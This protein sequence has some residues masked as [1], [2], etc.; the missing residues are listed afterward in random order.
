MAV[1]LGLLGCSQE[2]PPT[3]ANP[4][5][6]DLAPTVETAINLAGEQP[7]RDPAALSTDALLQES[8]AAYRQRFIQADGRVIDWEGNA[9][10]VSEGQAYALLRA[11]MA[12]DPATF[13]LTLQWAE[14]NLR[15]EGS[16]QGDSLWA[17]KW[18]QGEDGS[19]GVIDGNFA[20]D[21]DIDAATALILAARRWNRPDYEALAQ[22]KLADL[23]DFSTLM[24]PAVEAQNS[25]R[26]L[27]PGP[28]Q[29]FQ[30]SPGKVYLNPSYLA[31]YAFRLFAQ[32]DPDRNWAALVES[33]YR[34]LNQTKDL[35]PQG[36]PGDW[37]VLEM[38]TQQLAPVG[39]NSTLKSHYGFDAYRVWW[40]I[41]LDAAW[42]GEPRA[43]RFLTEHLGYLKT[44]WESQK[45][46]PAVLDLKGQ[47]LVD[48]E[49]TAQYAM[50][51]PAFLRIE[52]QIAESLRREK[53]LTAYRQ[54]IWDNNDAYYVQNLAWLGLFPAE[55]LPASLLKGTP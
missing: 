38:A 33:S 14:S 44:Q 51:Y 18:G 34:V 53:L 13:E 19:W 52:P 4:L 46:I 41:A 17:W 22:E 50:L 39:R 12:D 8:W 29:A 37:V 11:V 6:E 54:G 2:G 25:L 10:T 27:L 28:L 48:Y 3:A 47:A 26:Y 24:L 40:R 35:S 15:R 55:R 21:A 43:D 20:S 31:P 1:C 23:W 16:A 5:D 42:F 30:P 45:N 49:A 36:L 7:G 32:V 9:R